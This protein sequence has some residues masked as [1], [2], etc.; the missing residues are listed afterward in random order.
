MA[1]HTKLIGLS[2]RDLKNIK[3]FIS[4]FMGMIYNL[5]RKKSYSNKIQTFKYYI[6]NGKKLTEYTGEMFIMEDELCIR[7][8]TE[9]THYRS[10]NIT[11][12]KMIRILELDNAYAYG[13][14]LV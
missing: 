11:S 6:Q 8:D 1:K 4:Y 14:S 13:T 2:L 5:K 7:D 3:Y 12:K 9:Q 10:F